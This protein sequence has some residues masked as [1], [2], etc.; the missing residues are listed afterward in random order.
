MTD[1]ELQILKSDYENKIAKLN[2]K[3]HLMNYS[4]DYP[5]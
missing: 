3:V 1:E 4:L 2:I 5:I